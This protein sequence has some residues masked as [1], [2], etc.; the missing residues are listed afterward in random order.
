MDSTR[1]TAVNLSGGAGED[2]KRMLGEKKLLSE[3]DINK[4]ISTDVTFLK[5]AE[6][7]LRTANYQGAIKY[8]VKSLETNPDS[9]VLSPGILF[10]TIEYFFF[11]G[12]PDFACQS[13]LINK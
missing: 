7:L 12:S 6:H 10:E 8:I 9:K 1:R 3:E 2:L 11:P 13:L 5:Q 4:G